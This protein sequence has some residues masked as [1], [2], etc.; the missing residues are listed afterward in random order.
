MKRL[1]ILL[2]A[3]CVFAAIGCQNKVTNNVSKEEN[4][5]MLSIADA[6]GTPDMSQQGREAFLQ[7]PDFNGVFATEAGFVGYKIKD[8]KIYFVEK[9]DDDVKD[10]QEIWTDITDTIA[11][12]RNLNKLEYTNPASGLRETLTFDGFGY[13]SYDGSGAPQ[14]Y[15]RHDYLETYAGTWNIN[16]GGYEKVVIFDDGCITRYSTST[17]TANRTWSRL[18][19]RT[20][21]DRDVLKFDN[22]DSM[23]FNADGKTATYKSRNG[24]SFTATKQQQ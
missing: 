17:S 10:E 1:T 11:V 22:G 19:T 21:L 4:K 8:K 12:D 14:Y 7:T 15:T 16:G 2:M 20:I 3:V 6:G 18:T 24:G 13:Y 9:K 5:A 23:V